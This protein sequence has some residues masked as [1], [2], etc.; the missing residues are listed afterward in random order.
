MRQEKVFKTISYAIVNAN[1]HDIENITSTFI[2]MFH[3]DLNYITKKKIKIT[4]LIPDFQTSINEYLGKQGQETKIEFKGREQSV[5][6]NYIVT[7]GE[8]VFKDQKLQGYIVKIEKVKSEKSFLNPNVNNSSLESQQ[9]QNSSQI[10]KTKHGGKNNCRFYF[11]FDQ[12]SGNY[13]GEFNID[14]NL[15]M[16][17]ISSVKQDETFDFS[18]VNQGVVKN[19]KVE[20]TNLDEEQKEEQKED[21]QKIDYGQ[22][23]RI[24]RLLNGQLF[25]YEDFRKEEDE[26]EELEEEQRGERKG[27]NGLASIR[28]D[29][30]EEEA[31]GGHANIYKSRRTFVA[32][33]DESRS[34]NQGSMTCFKWSGALLILCMGVIGLLNYILTQDQFQQIQD[35]YLMME[36][37]NSRVG[38]G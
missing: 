31:E 3:I 24:M 10:I 28:G 34:V 25:D 14:A 36:R 13:Q 5:E 1:S 23:I 18:Q 16:S 38:E 22:G 27:G 19:P 32:F 7:A 30:D 20:Q 33:L 6:G 8:V 29:D 9:D 4:D 15:Q 12:G 35:G 11:A 21:S 2:S 26:E 17:A 37:S